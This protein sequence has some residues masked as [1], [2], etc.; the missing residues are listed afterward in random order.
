MGLLRSGLLLAQLAVAQAA[1]AAAPPLPWTAG[2]HAILH[3]AADLNYSLTLASGA[4]LAGGD[5][6]LAGTATAVTGSDPLLGEWQGLQIGDPLSTIRYY[7]EHDAF[8]FGHVDGL[9][10]FPQFSLRGSKLESCIA[11]QRGPFLPGS[12]SSTTQRGCAGSDGP[13]LLFENAT[14]RG[15]PGAVETMVL[16]AFDHFTV[17]S[18]AMQGQSGPGGALVGVHTGSG[19]SMEGEAPPLGTVLTTLLIVRPELTRAYRGWGAFLRM[20]HNT[21]RGRGSGLGKLSYWDDNEA[22]YSYWGQAR[23]LNAEGV[24]E[25]NMKL[26]AASYKQQGVPIGAWEVDC[27]FEYEIWWPTYGGWCW[28]DWLH[29]NTTAFPSGGKL[30]SLVGNLPMTYYVSPFCADNVHRK[31]Y[32]GQY[33]FLNVTVGGKVMGVV[34][35]N[36]SEAFY[37]EILSVGVRQWNMEMLF[38][39]FMSD[40]ADGASS[41]GGVAS[42]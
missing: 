17:Q 1:A 34:A 27:N 10:A 38:T 29:W 14:S 13:L 32:G 4:L 40:R 23:N 16:S 22:G 6:S 31:G 18:P 33:D 41:L 21:T 35:P 19:N 25:D 9:P 36:S 7:A 2:K 39:D 37:T 20:A 12:L 11:F 3:V 28:K 42:P 5:S 24:P 8:T 15:T 30:S 26:L